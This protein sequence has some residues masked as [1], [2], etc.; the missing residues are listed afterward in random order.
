M[1][2]LIWTQIAFNHN[3]QIAKSIVRLLDTCTKVF[4]KGWT[5]S[6]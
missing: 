3:L 1:Y 5:K 4:E 6:D 2:V